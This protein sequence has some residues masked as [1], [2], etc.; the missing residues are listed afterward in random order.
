MLIKAKIYPGAR[1]CNVVEKK[2]D[3]F[4]VYVRK[5]PQ[6]GLATKATMLA[7]AVYFGIPRSNVRLVRGSKKRNK[8]I[9]VIL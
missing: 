5:E 7:L 1:E 3:T 6:E 8:I 4:D 2:P 9:N